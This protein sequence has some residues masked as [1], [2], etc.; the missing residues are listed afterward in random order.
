MN[1]PYPK[2]RKL[3][4]EKQKKIKNLKKRDCGL[5]CYT[6][7]ELSSGCIS[8]KTGSWLC[9]FV[10]KKCNLN[11]S[12]CP[13]LRP[14]F[15]KPRKDPEMEEE[16]LRVDNQ[17]CRDLY[18][19]E[20]VLNLRK[21]TIKGIS[22]SGGEPFL[23]INKVVK[24]AKISKKVLPNVYLWIYTNGILVTEEKLKS[25]QRAGIKEVR[26]D[27]ASTNFSD[28]IL[29]KMRL[30]K[31]YMEKVTIEIPMYSPEIVGVLLPKLKKVAKTGVTQ[32]NCAE[33]ELNK[34]NK[35]KLYIPETDV[36]IHPEYNVPYPY[37]SRFL[38][39]DVMEYIEKNSIPITVNDCS[40][41]AKCAQKLSRSANMMKM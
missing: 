9:V 37:W 30:A 33:V 34:N 26:F 24:L 21:D 8:C 11:C 40:E 19:Y 35:Q 12:Y 13:Q 7:K 36:Y 28:E 14:N 1:Y 38:T 22:F 18:S 16:D 25:L 23:V 41:D 5:T 2:F 6:G 10:T 39:Y 32:L 31:K 20:F 3:L 27:W 17:L 4:K 15:P 29:E